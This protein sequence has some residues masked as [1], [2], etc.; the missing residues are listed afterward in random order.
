MDIFLALLGLV[1]LVLAGDLLVRGAVN[2]SLRLGIPALIVSL[3][4]VAIG[5][6]APEL[7]ISIDAVMAGAPGIAVGNVVGSNTAN[8]LLVLGV[9]AL[10]FGLGRPGKNLRSSYVQMLLGTALFVGLTF[11]AP[12]NWGHGIVLLGLYILFMVFAIVSARTAMNFDKTMEQAADDIDGA[13]PCASWLKLCL[14]WV[15][16]LL[17]CRWGLIFW[18]GAPPVLRDPMA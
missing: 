15:W 3:T 9:P 17:G 10:I 6:S 5:T 8:V 13:E 1:I 11:F 12:L 2:L 18:L 16:E 14:T 7:L 4:I